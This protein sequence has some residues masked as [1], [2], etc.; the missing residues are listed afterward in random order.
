MKTSPFIQ[1]VVQRMRARSL[2]LRKL[3]RQAGLD[4]SF[5]S[6]VLT[7]KR[8]PPSDEKT[9]EKM[10]RCLGLDPEMLVLSTGVIPSRLRPILEK[11]EAFRQLC[12]Q[13]LK[14]KI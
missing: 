5:F 4:P 1:L 3:A 7:G 6:K 14:G 2:S 12:E 9:L 11:P 10:A 13:I 8:S